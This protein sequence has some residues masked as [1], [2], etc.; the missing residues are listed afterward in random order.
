MTFTQTPQVKTALFNNASP[1]ADRSVNRGAMTVTPWSQVTIAV[2]DGAGDPVTTG[3]TG[4]VTG[5][6]RASG[7]GNLSAFATTI[8]LATDAWAWQPQLAAETYF[9]F[10]VDGTLS[11]GYHLSISVTSMGD[12]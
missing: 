12:C 10:S 8:N 3:V 9:E 4:I 11:A 2:V 7:Q 6:S 5:S 1:L